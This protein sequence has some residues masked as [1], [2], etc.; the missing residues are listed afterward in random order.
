MNKGEL[1]AAISDKAGVSQKEAGDCLDAFFDVVCD[2]V[3]SGGE[4]GVT[5]YIKFSQVERA[6][7]M[8][9]NPQ[10]G[11]KIYVP[12]S[13]AVKISAGSKLKAAAKG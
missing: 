7:R 1:I 6:A 4:V 5:G 2:Q 9:R 10:T 13:K 8:G 3:G 12:A 11:E